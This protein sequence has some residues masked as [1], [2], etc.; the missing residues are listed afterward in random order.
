MNLTAKQ[1]AVGNYRGIYNGLLKPV[2]K[3]IECSS[4]Y[5]CFPMDSSVSINKK[6]NNVR[7]SYLKGIAENQ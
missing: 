7:A 3:C 2:K 4:H 5:S 1:F 6:K